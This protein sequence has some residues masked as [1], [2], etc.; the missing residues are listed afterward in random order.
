MHVDSSTR[1][2]SLQLAMRRRD[3]EERLC[4]ACVI[5]IPPCAFAM[6]LVG[7]SQKS[8]LRGRVRIGREGR[9]TLSFQSEKSWL[10]KPS[11]SPSA[12]RPL[13]ALEARMWPYY[14]A[15]GRRGVFDFVS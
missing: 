15:A 10:L 4:V 11:C 13:P 8:H 1:A 14:V 3:P 5:V 2:S 7:R 9:G 12:F 6:R